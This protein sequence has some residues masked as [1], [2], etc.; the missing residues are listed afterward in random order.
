MLN[1]N[2]V[3]IYVGSLFYFEITGIFNKSLVSGF[4]L[5]DNKLKYVFNSLFE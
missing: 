3:I 5:M 4:I 2:K 1:T